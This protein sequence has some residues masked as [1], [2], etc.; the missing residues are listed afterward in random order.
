MDGL[1]DL[2]LGTVPPLWLLI[3]SSEAEGLILACC[4]V[5]PMDLPLGEMS[6][7]GGRLEGAIFRSL[8][9]TRRVGRELLAAALNFTKALFSPEQVCIFTDSW[10]CAIAGRENKQVMRAKSSICAGRGREGCHLKAA[11][12]GAARWSR[13]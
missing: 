11:V 5:F 12:A 7:R 10:V 8:L 4:M 2:R 13:R 3:G 9:Q 1:A 6:G